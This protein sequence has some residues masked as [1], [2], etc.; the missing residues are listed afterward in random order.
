[1]NKGKWEAIPLPLPGIA[2]QHRL[3]AKVD[4]LM[5]LCDRLEAQQADAE[6]AHIQL[7][8]ALLDS[9]TQASD[10]TDLVAHWQRLAEHFHTL[11]TTEPSID[12]L[13]Q[14]LLQLAVMGK[15]VPQDPNDEPASD[16]LKRIIEGNSRLLAEGKLKKQKPLDEVNQ[17][18]SFYL[19]AGWEWVRLGRLS[20]IKGGKRLPAGTTF[21]SKET[22]HIYIQVTNM[23]GGTITEHNLKFIDESTQA[24]IKQYTISK[25]DLYITI[26]GTIGDVGVIPDH[27]DGMNLTENAAKIVFQK[28]DKHWLK[29][30]L[31]SQFVQRQFSDS[32][33]QL[34]QPKLALHRIADSILALPPISEQ[35]RIVVKIDQLMALCDQLKTRLIQSRQLNEQLTSTLVEQ[36]VA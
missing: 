32:T 2:E 28:I 26:A 25:D 31:S 35:R 4:E 12:A 5:A 14:A 34:A 10:A 9:L 15:L 6:I 33:N 11:F 20:Q 3:V 30:A 7:V 22:P 1:M 17:E 27:F 24:A 19:P 18:Q 8:Q 13:K 23:K 36:A 21:S 16:L 29:F